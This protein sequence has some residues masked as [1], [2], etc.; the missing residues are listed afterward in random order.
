MSSWNPSDSELDQLARDLRPSEL[1]GDRAE[2]IRTSV[3]VNAASLQQTRRP[4]WPM[5]AAGVGLPLA[6]AAAIVIWLGGRST[7][8]PDLRVGMVGDGARYSIT[9]DWPERTLDLQD[10]A[11]AI[12]AATTTNERFHVHAPDAELV[13][14]DARFSV[15]V[16][17]D[18]LSSVAVTHGRVELR[19]AGAKVVFLA[20]GQAWT[21]EIIVQRDVL[22]P[23]VAP[24]LP[25]SSNVDATPVAVPDVPPGSSPKSPAR[26]ITRTVDTQRA[27]TEP[28]TRPRPAVPA[29][30][31]PVAKPPTALPGE[32]SFRLGMTAL[33]AN[34][35]AAASK[36]FTAACNAASVA[37][38]ED[39]C[40]W[41]GAAARRAGE[42]IIA[43][44][45]LERFLQRFATS[46]RAG[47]A[48]ALLGW[49]VFEAGDLDRAERLFKQAV[50]D[51][52]PSVR[53]SATR[54]LSAVSRTRH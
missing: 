19:V 26:P 8:A 27:P 35:P 3:L 22:V 17:S 45:A 16:R 54:G 12:A 38:A 4:R 34:D 23:A 32:V 2:Q 50:N 20:A 13:T 25:A 1:T 5:V 40:F 53:E 11:M 44:T 14:T 49:I 43:R 51:R 33:R 15:A 31:S 30:V 52:V 21:R 48:A 36:A 24:T 42:T 10:G 37:L 28:V 41:V 39:A 46:A 6:A 47:E 29:E 18:H 7:E 9:S